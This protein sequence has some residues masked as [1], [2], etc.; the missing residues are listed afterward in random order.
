MIY[1]YTWLSLFPASHNVI[2]NQPLRPIHN[3]HTSHTPSLP[4][5]HN[6]ASPSRRRS[7]TESQSFFTHCGSPVPHVSPPPQEVT[8]NFC[9]THQRVAAAS[10]LHNFLTRR[11]DIP[12]LSPYDTS[13]QDKHTGVK[14]TR[15]LRE[16]NPGPL[17]PEARIIPLDQAADNPESPTQYNVIS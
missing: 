12:S 17:A 7:H 11:Y 14:N 9:I 4:R 16:L 2:H 6:V 1:V 15:L 13:W 3:R 8:Y 10:Y 5:H